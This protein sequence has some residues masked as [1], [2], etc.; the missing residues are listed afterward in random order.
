V[1]AHHHALLRAYRPRIL[2]FRNP[3]R[4]AWERL[5]KR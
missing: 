3:V 1:Q 2:S 4:Q 5:W